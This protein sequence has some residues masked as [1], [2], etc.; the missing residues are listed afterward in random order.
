MRL[1]ATPGC[2]P[3]VLFRGVGLRH[4]W[5]RSAGLW[6][7]VVAA[8][9]PSLLAEVPEWAFPRHFWLRAPAA[10]PRH[11]WVGS[12]GR[13]GGRFRGVGWGLGGEFPVLCVFVGRR[14]RVVSV[15]VCVLCV[16]GGGSGVGLSFVCVGVCVCVC[17]CG[18]WWLVSPAG[19]RC[20]CRWCCG[21]CVL[22]L[23]LRHSWRRFLSAPGWVSL[24]VVVGVPRHSWLRAP[25]AVPGHSWLGSAGGGGVWLLVPPGRG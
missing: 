17:V 10:V 3:L 8:G 1:P 14:V 7:M 18:V 9:G 25:D 6:G 12:A 22:W 23:V 24:P 11:S 4:S 16:R 20:W 21:W 15:L 2:G 19:A 5:L 13:G